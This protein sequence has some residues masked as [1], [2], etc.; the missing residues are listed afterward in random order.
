VPKVEND[1]LARVQLSV[2]T[3]TWNAETHISRLIRS[4][5]AQTD[6]DFE[7]VVADGGST[8]KTIALLRDAQGL[9][10]RLTVQ[11]DFGIY[12]ALNRAVHESRGDYY[13]VLGSDDVLLPNA[14]CD[15]KN[16][17]SQTGADIVAARVRVNGRVMQ[18][19][20]APRWISGM[21]HYI[22][23]HA[24]GAAFRKELHRRFG[25]YSRALPIAADKLFVLRA[26]DGG[27][28]LGD[29]DFIA[30]QYDSTGTSGVDV[31]GAITENFRVQLRTGS[32]R[33]LQLPILVIRL[34]R[35]Y[36]RLR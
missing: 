15:Y 9:N 23:S 13:I 16:A 1:R 35:H 28:S 20:R 32:P 31:A 5:E 11:E 10:L 22:P 2:L 8:D 27:A 33:W 6:R 26:L 36:R 18:R 17:I 7:W 19:R 25:D 34:L 21:A 3:A 30:G 24:V 12:D 29:A 4:L 14:I